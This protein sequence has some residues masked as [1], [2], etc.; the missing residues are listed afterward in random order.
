MGQKSSLDVCMASP[1]AAAPS[2]LSSCICVITDFSG[3][4]HLISTPTAVKEGKIRGNINIQL[5]ESA[6]SSLLRLCRAAKAATTSQLHMLGSLLLPPRLRH[7]A[8]PLLI[9][10]PLKGCHLLLLC[11]HVLV[12]R[13]QLGH[14]LL[15]HHRCL[16]PSRVLH[17][18]LLC[19]L[20][21]RSLQ[22]SD[23]VARC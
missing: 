1:G 8:P 21:P 3:F 9:Q 12:L 18:S 19:S 22:F 23:L 17:D 10:L 15:H 5:A 16:L 4:T 20:L 11:C 2:R 13:R 14:H 7:A 6:I